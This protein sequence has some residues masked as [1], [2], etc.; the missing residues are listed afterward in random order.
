MT[1]DLARRRR[2]AWARRFKPDKIKLLLVAEAPPS[3]LE[4]YFYFPD[5]STHD[6]LFRYVATSI[7]H[8]EPTRANKRELLWR[9]RDRGVFLVDLCPDPL[10]ANRPL[11]S[12]VPGLMRRVRTLR[13]EKVILIKATAYDAAFGVLSTGG[14]PVIDERVPFPGS[15]QQ[16]RFEE[17]FQRALLAQPTGARSLRRGGVAR[18]S[19]VPAETG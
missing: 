5:V 14:L 4:R 3:A 16:R 8:V 7:L 13:P 12:C 11:V 9:L 10:D 2:G 15:G 1:P 6:S 17:A 19:A 18:A